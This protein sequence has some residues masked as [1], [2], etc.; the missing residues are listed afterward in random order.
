MDEETIKIVA[1]GDLSPDRD[2]PE[3]IFDPN[4]H[5]LREADIA[6]GQLETPFSERGSPQV[7]RG[8]HK[9]AHPKNVSALSNAG[10]DVIS[11]ASN[12]ALDFGYDAFFDTIDLLRKSDIEVV[13]V[14]NNFEEARKPVILE[15]KGIRVAFLAYNSITMAWLRGYA[16]DIDRAGCNPLRAYTFYEPIVFGY[17]P[18]TPGKAITFAYPEDKE[19]MIED[20]KR[21]KAKADIVVVSQHAGVVYVHAV[22]AMYQKEIAYT[23]IDAGAD[24]VLQHHAHM[25]KGI[26]TYKGKAIFYGLGNFAFETMTPRRETRWRQ[27][28]SD[29]Y[30]V[31]VEPGWEGY[32]MPVESRKT[33]AVKILISDK[34]VQ[35]VTYIPCY[36]NQQAQAEILA[37]SDKRSEEVYQYVEELSRSE[38][39]NIQFHWE[40]DE[41]LVS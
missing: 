4:A 31:K 5:I 12:H 25:L 30:G 23:A 32:P 41:V 18:G 24:I 37:R 3:S 33:L 9:I 19:N 36:I 14:G 10:F 38:G 22:I 15:R 13:G 29:Y 39:L 7:G 34:K 11:F 26:E 16:A 28:V 17:Q 20:I 27:E 6:F 40:G 35:K 8:A 2:G 21:A 1:V